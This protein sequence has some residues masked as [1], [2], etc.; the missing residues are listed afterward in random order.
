MPLILTVVSISVRRCHRG[1]I[2]GSSRL[3]QAAYWGF[4]APPGLGSAN[5]CEPAVYDDARQCRWRGRERDLRPG[6][7]SLPCIR[8]RS[9]QSLSKGTTTSLLSKCQKA[10]RSVYR[11]AISDGIQWSNLISVNNPRAMHFD[12]P[13]IASGDTFRIFGRNLYVAP[14]SPTV[15][16][17]Q[18]AAPRQ[19]KQKRCL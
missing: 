1:L 2:R 10:S 14:G 15:G 19:F 17:T 3:C 11:I 6:S 16:G 9:K 5:H 4:F 12:K 13:E 18:F 7:Y 8:R